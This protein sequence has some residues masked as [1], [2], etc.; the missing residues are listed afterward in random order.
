MFLT[1]RIKNDFLCASGND[2][3]VSKSVFNS[4]KSNLHCK[5]VCVCVCILCALS[6][7]T[8]PKIIC[9][10]CTLAPREGYDIILYTWANRDI[11]WNWA[12][13]VIMFSASVVWWIWLCFCFCLSLNSIIMLGYALIFLWTIEYI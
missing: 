1:N 2:K 6:K 7:Q 13:C 11:C 8:Q 4:K 5:C 12:F 9:T 10:R 3:F